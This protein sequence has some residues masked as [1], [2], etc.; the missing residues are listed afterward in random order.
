MR[1]LAREQAVTRAR[2]TLKDPLAQTKS[3]VRTLAASQTVG[4]M[5]DAVARREV[6]ARATLIANLMADLEAERGAVVK[7][8]TV[9]P[10]AGAPDL[11]V[12]VAATAT[13][14]LKAVLDPSAVAREAR[15]A[16]QITK[17][18]ALNPTPALSP[19]ASTVDS[20][21]EDPREPLEMP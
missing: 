21:R 4:L 14:N 17:A 5:A 18:L 1:A 6:D 12:V 2:V 3:G 16:T 13:V 7:T 9:N 19:T 10:M 11:N 15:A 20:S 8:A